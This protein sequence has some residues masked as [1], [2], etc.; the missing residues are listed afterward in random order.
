VIEAL[1]GLEE[2]RR[3]VVELSEDE[4]EPYFEK[5]VEEVNS[6]YRQ[7]VQELKDEK[8][9]L[10][11]V[12]EEY[13]QYIKLKLSLDDIRRRVAENI[14]Y[15]VWLTITDGVTG[16]IVDNNVDVL[17]YGTTRHELLSIVLKTYGFAKV[18]ITGTDSKTG[19][20][21]V[22]ATV[23]NYVAREVLGQE[24]PEID[25]ILRRIRQVINAV[26]SVL[27]DYLNI[28]HGTSLQHDA[29]MSCVNSVL[30][31]L[32]GNGKVTVNMLIHL[33]RLHSQVIASHISDPIRA[34]AGVLDGDGFLE[35]R[36][37]GDYGVCVSLAPYT[38]KGYAILMLLTYLE[39]K[40]LLTINGFHAEALGFR[41]WLS[42][43]TR[44]S[45]ALYMKH[46]LRL[47]RVRVL[48]ERAT[49]AIIR[50]SC[51]DPSA[52]I[53]AVREALK[54]AALYGVHIRAE[55]KVMTD[56]GRRALVL[57]L[58]LTG[59]EP[60]AKLTEIAKKIAEV[61]RR[62]GIGAR[63]YPKSAIVEIKRGKIEVAYMLHKLGMLSELIPRGVDG[64]SLKVVLARL[65]ELRNSN[66]TLY[67]TDSKG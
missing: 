31:E 4:V 2:G 62:Y 15:A 1:R 19:K 55:W 39:Q 24:I 18:T 27:I 59:G 45:V 52:A 53:L 17:Q 20:L 61:M 9:A 12:Q 57:H 47:E 51:V 65:E 43:Q 41:I 26:K 35:K 60:N 32:Y 48:S 37:E 16:V 46:P 50:K 22:V 49:T 56:R 34:L 13:E 8:T 58:K 29:R 11:R 7:L 30:K 10:R 23:S 67:T 6:R 28:T 66:V 63:Q 21:H 38:V 5:L 36:K 54:V 42:P 40:G 33:A 14:D 3:R 25:E 64:L 44:S